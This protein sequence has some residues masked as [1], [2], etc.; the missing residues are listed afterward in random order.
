VEAFHETLIWLEETAIAV[1]P[2]GVAGTMGAAG[3]VDLQTGVA[4]LGDSKLFDGTVLR[5]VELL[6]D[7]TPND[8]AL[9]RVK[10]RTKLRPVQLGD[11]ERITVGDRIVSIGNPL[12]LEHTL[13]DGLV[14]ARRILEGRKMIQM[15][16]PVSPGNSGG[17][18]F[19][20][21]GEVIG[22]TT[23]QYAGGDFFGR[24]QNLNLAMPINLLRAMI[25]PAY[26]GR[27]R[28]GDSRGTPNSW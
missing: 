3:S 27:R 23:A 4:C 24:A 21:R 2:L 18:L 13:T 25:R 19:N 22:V 5:E 12:G 6:D 16:V 9:L 10:T 26:P 15:S 14:S 8:L 17:P 20:M 28:F 1:R 7:S 11:S